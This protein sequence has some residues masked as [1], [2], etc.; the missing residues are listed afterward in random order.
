MQLFVLAEMVK[1]TIMI[2]TTNVNEYVQLK[3]IIVLIVI[4]HNYD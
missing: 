1:V 4:V 3:P 2:T